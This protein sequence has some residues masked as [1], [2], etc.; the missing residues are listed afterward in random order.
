M[1]EIEVLGYDRFTEMK[2]GPKFVFPRRENVRLHL[3]YS[4]NQ[5]VSAGALNRK[6]TVCGYSCDQ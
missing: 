6:A 3:F 1:S 5:G 4:A 2:A